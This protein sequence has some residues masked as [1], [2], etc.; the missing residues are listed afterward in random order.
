MRRILKFPISEEG[1]YLQEP[2]ERFLSVQKQGDQLVLWAITE[3]MK[4][5]EDWYVYGLGTGWP[6]LDNIRGEYLGT[7][8]DGAYVWHFFVDRVHG[9]Y[10][11]GWM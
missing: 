3:T 11:C 2:I 6:L 1:T 5:E 8:Q 7:V 4:P 10:D 9:A